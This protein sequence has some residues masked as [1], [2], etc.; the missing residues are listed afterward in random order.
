MRLVLSVRQQREGV[1]RS[2]LAAEQADAAVADTGKADG[3]DR[4]SHC[5][6]LAVISATAAIVSLES[7]RLMGSLRSAER[8]AAR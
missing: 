4:P 8:S 3:L 6:L 2:H 1:G 7:G 5:L